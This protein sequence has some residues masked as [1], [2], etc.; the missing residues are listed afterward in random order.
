ETLTVLLISSLFV[1]LA[2]RLQREDILVLGRESFIFVAVMMFIA[3]PVSVLVATVGSSL[4]WRE[5]CFMSFMAPRGIV[6]AAVSSV[7]ALNLLNV[8]YPRAIDMVSITFLMV[9]VSVVVY[10]ILGGPLAR[11]LGLVH[12]NA[13]GILFVGA[14]EWA[15]ALASALQK[16]GCPVMLIDTSWENIGKARMAGLPCYHGSALAETTREEIDFSALGRLLAVTSNNAVNALACL[17]YTEDFGRQEV[18]QLSLPSSQA[19]RHE[20]VPW[21]HRGRFLFG[22]DLT[23]RRLG[24]LFGSPPSVKST[25]LSAEF[26][27]EA[28]QAN[29][30][31]TAIPLFIL[32]PDGFVQVCA[33]DVAS[34][35]QAGDMIIG[36]VSE[37]CQNSQESDV[38][39][40]DKP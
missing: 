22:K 32:K 35:P 6:A 23:Y 12:G 34:Y 21:E 10:G 14:H 7:F 24:E 28:Y 40:T 19:G 26:G 25:K 8:G 2:A 27:F 39:L 3:R 17:I 31:D 4:T 29:Y 20:R 13:Q 11:K 30:G 5:R 33:S 37:G 16:E 1:I 9:I 38:P 15:R 18:Y 36:I